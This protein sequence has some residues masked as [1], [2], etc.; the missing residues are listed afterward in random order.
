MILQATVGGSTVVLDIHT[1]GVEPQ[2]AIAGHRA[3]VEL[4]PVSPHSWSLIIDGRSYHLSVTSHQRGYHVLLD[5]RLMH[6][7][8]QSELDR[9]IEQMGM[10]SSNN[11]KQGDV[12]AAIPGMIAII[13]VKE[14]QQVAAG[15]PLLILE[16]MKMENELVAPVGGIVKQIAVA[17]GDTVEKGTLLVRIEQS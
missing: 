5:D 17:T 14:G 4:L 3:D 8:L 15:D 12:L 16:A 6:V 13:E 10:G 2:V 1:Q 7:T 11:R 9:T